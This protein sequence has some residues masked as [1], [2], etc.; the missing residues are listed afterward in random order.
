MLT[1]ARQIDKPVNRPQQVILGNVIV[2]RELM[3]QRALRLVLRSQHRNH[4]WLIGTIESA[5]K[6]QINKSFSIE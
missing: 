3:K 4:P 6:P 1:D 2:Y 5:A